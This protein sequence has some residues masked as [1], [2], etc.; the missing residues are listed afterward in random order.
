MKR[1]YADIPE[2]QMHYRHAG[3]GEAVILLHMSGSASDEFEGAGNILA[4]DYAVYALDLLAFG[5]SDEPPRFYSFADHAKTVISFMDAVGIQK[6][7]IAG[8]LV[9][10]NIAVHIATTYPE[11]V[12]GLMLGQLCYYAGD[13]D[14]FKK[15]RGA[16]IFSKVEIKDD[17]SHMIE[18]WKR[19]AQYGESAEV[20]NDRAICLH[21][22]RDYGEALHWA[23]CEDENFEERLP[24]IKVPTVCL[25]YS[26]TGN[27]E[28]IKAA[29]DIIPNAQYEYLEKAT[30]YIARATPERFAALFLKYFKK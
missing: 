19:S 7:Y 13:S 16:P 27:V 21:K 15:L 30:P 26:N 9:G 22:A 23:L 11:R 8:N 24:Q 28:G 10:A 25:N 20:S 6:A 17:G 14:H 12:K 3:N 1:A 5:E 18:Y 4:K 29:A 2:G